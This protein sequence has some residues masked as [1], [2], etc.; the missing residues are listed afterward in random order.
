[1]NS[2]YTCTCTIHSCHSVIAGPYSWVCATSDRHF[3]VVYSFYG[4]VQVCVNKDTLQAV[5]SNMLLNKIKVL[6]PVISVFFKCRH[7]VRLKQNNKQACITKTV[8]QHTQFSKS[9]LLIATKF[10]FKKKH[11]TV[12]TADVFRASETHCSLCGILLN[13]VQCS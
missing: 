5:P 7:T 13:T 12:K 9:T 6:L 8:V 3:H 10:I 1:M 2:I 11:A 4:R